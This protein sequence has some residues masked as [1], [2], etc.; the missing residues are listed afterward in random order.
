MSAGIGFCISSDC[1]HHGKQT[2][3]DEKPLILNKIAKSHHRQCDRRKL[4]IQLLK[5]VHI[6]RNNEHQHSNH[7]SHRHKGHH[8]GIDHSLL[9]QRLGLSRFLELYRHMFHGCF[10]TAGR[11]SCSDHLH[12]KLRKHLGML[13]Q[14][15]GKTL[16]FLHVRAH[17]VDCLLHFLIFGGLR[18]HIEC[19]YNG[20]TRSGNA[21]ELPA[22][23]RHVTGCGL[24]A[25]IDIDIFGQHILLCY[26]KH[27]KTLILQISEYEFLVISVSTAFDFFSGL[28]D[29]D[30]SP[31]RHYA[32]PIKIPIG[33]KHGLHHKKSLFFLLSNIIYPS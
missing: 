12:Q 25:Q 11:F 24:T 31:S 19:L 21:G 10:Q 9:D 7:N 6:T 32:S 18:Q 29:C 28:I 26:F 23:Y 2:Q 8:N 20:H 14:G 22:E 17:R 27:N 4:C 3:N 16:T 15:I 13:C 30:I 5:H 33:I 1:K